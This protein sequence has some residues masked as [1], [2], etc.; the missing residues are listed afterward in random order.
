MAEP[1]ELAPVTADARLW[2][3]VPEWHWVDD[4]KG[5]RRPSSAAFEDDPDGS[6]LSCTVA[7]E[8]TLAKA[9]DPVRAR[10][11]AFALA[12]F[13]ASV[14]FDKGQSI[15]RDP[16]P[17]EPAHVVLVGK[18]SKSVGRA[19]AKASVWAWPPPGRPYPEHDPLPEPQPEAPEENAAPET[20]A[21]P[22]V[23]EPAAIDV[24]RVG[25]VVVGVGLGISA[26]V[27]LVW[28]FA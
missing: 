17:E 5:G 14:A 18:K 8:S 7:A 16:T 21:P 28:L 10:E 15:V 27:A 3:R 1:T 24:V 12:E 11:E 4:G 20:E 25:F 13:P 9:F 26:L 2:R 6:P 23:R 19:L 22:I